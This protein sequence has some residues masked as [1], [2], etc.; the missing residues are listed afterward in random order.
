MRFWSQIYTEKRGLAGRKVKA[1]HKM[2]INFRESI[3]KQKIYLYNKFA[4]CIVSLYFCYTNCILLLMQ[5]APSR[6]L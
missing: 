5:F 2:A 1:R 3:E 6:G 4:N